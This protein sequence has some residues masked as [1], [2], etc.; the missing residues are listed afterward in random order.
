MNHPVSTEQLPLPRDSQLA[1]ALATFSAIG[2]A[3][4][5][6]FWQL[7][8]EPGL[9]VGFMFGDA[10]DPAAQS[11]LL[12]WL[13]VGALLPLLLGA[14]VRL[15]YGPGASQALRRLATLWAPLVLLPWVPTLFDWRHAQQSTTA[16]L[17]VL[18][19]FAF[20]GRAL[21]A[22][23][24]EVRRLSRLEV[25]ALRARA[26]HWLCLLLV[27]CA[28]LAYTAFTAYF[29]ILNHRQIATTAFDLGIYDNLLYNAL[30][31]R[32][33]HSPVLFG[34]GNRNYLAGHAELGMVLF[35]P[36]YAIRPGSETMLIMQSVVL[37]M[38][39]VPLYSFA[40]RLIP[41]PGAVA[42][43]LAYL[44]FAPLHG[45]HFYD[46]HWLPLAIFFHFWLYYAIAA[47]KTWLVV[48]NVL[49]LLSIREDVAIGI[50]MLGVFLFVTGTRVRLG[51]TLAVSAGVW[52]VFDKF[53]LMPSM[54][55]WY[56][57]ALY[58][59]LFADGRSSFGSVIVTL[60]TNPMYALTTFMRQVKLEYG[61]HMVASLAFLPLRRLPFL[62]LLIPGS[63]ITLMTTGYPPTVQI[64]FQYTTHWIPYLF[65][66]CVMGLWLMRYESAGD[67]KRTAALLVLCFT[68]L[69]HSYNFGAV[70]QQESFTGGFGKKSFEMSA[71]AKQRYEH[72]MSLVRRIPL[73]ASVA[74]TEAV[75]PHISTRL[76]AYAFRYDFGPVDYMLF[77]RHE[78][79]GDSRKVLVDQV[80]RVSYRLVQRAGEFYLFKKG[81]ADAATN[82]AWRELGVPADTAQ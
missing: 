49:V 13:G 22:R 7:S 74:A 56:F 1:L 38:A 68:V 11:T 40:A 51:I 23:A 44:L 47:R 20:A 76:D 69:S 17:L 14:G 29:T 25:D 43:S 60:L 59:E 8:L 78:I 9:R 73:A 4:V 33:F 81:S 71:A 55:P 58:N 66:T 32:F 30:H 45:P 70:L 31:G 26:P 62:L 35:L 46:F 53:V 16:Y 54:G 3:L 82:D 42:L 10:M 2:F 41:R 50:S 28:G 79:S 52:F 77:S 64:S 6:L 5:L 63:V 24:L 27:V 39:C 19:L 21:L 18:S 37:G 57:E 48:L 72:L 34:P 80:S 12:S 65:L 15:Q 75:N 61:L 36:F 67:S